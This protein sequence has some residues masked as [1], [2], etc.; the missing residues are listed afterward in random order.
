MLSIGAVKSI[1][2]LFGSSGEGVSFDI[3]SRFF[4]YSSVSLTFILS[5]IIFVIVRLS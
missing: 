4:T 2:S 5:V 1:C 3:P